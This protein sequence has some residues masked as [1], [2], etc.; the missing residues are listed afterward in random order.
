MK[1]AD[2]FSKGELDIGRTNVVKHSI[3]LQDG[4]MPVRLKPYR[5]PPVL[6]KEIERQVAQL[7]EKGLIKPAS[8]A[9]SS[10][11][12]MVRKKDFV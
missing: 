2:V 10:T 9:W 5:H 6:E 4:A 11:V 1:Y 12:V 7:Q 3:P 8:G